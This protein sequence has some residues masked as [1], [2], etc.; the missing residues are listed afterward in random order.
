MDASTADA[1]HASPPARRNRTL[2]LSVAVAGAVVAGVITV[3]VLSLDRSGP[4]AAGDSSV[5]STPAPTSA[6]SPTPEEVP[7]PVLVTVP[8]IESSEPLD[9]PSALKV[10]WDPRNP[11]PL[12]NIDDI[13]SGGPPPD[14][15]PP[16]DE[17]RFEP[18]DTVTWLEGREPVLVLEIGNEARAYPIQ[19]MTWHELVNDTFGDRPVTVSYCP[20]CN[21]AVAY[22]RRLPSQGLV[23]D[24]GTSGSLYNS[25]LVMYDR[26]TESLWSHFTAEAIVGH[27]TGQVLDTIPVAT[28]SW[29]E[30]RQAHPDGLVLSR[31]TGFERGYGRNPYAGYDDADSTPFGFSGDPDP[32]LPPQTRVVTVQGDV[33]SVAVVTEHLYDRR[34]V[35]LTVDGR[36]LVALLSRGTASGLDTGR[37]AGGRDVGASGVF[38]PVVDGRT[39]TFEPAEDSTFRDLETGSTWSIL[40]V[41]LDGPL[42]GK[43]LEAVEH[44][45]TFW[46]AIAAF[47]PDTVVVAG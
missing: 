42:A 29:D 21:S 22:D 32:R 2:A 11:E 3:V 25:A 5:T 47:R 24:F 30:Y 16:I 28:V 35:E 8:Q 34:V 4:V 17:P 40:G 12:V 14:G 6:P 10:P 9:V 37:V 38:V 23:L 19:V 7:E 15:I 45:D 36:E 44:L 20:L 18:A 39:L 26:Q 43:R 27:L 1:D 41:A 31:E 46:F 33:D 13:R